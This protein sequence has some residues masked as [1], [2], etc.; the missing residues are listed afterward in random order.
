MFGWGI[1][2]IVTI[3]MLAVPA[4]SATT[5]VLYALTLFFLT[6][7]YG[8]MLFYMGESFPAPVRGTGANVAHVMAP[9]GGLAGSGLLTLLLATGLPMSGSAIF[10]GSVP[11]LVSALFM[12]GA[13]T[14][15]RAGD[16]TREG[17]QEGSGVKA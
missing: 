2:G 12:L 11:M 9:L 7:P 15:N 10:A 6:G 17:H 1:G 8:A 5:F 4:G 13:H 16:H 3:V 14:T